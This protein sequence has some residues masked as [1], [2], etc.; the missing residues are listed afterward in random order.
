[1]IREQED[2]GRAG[3][4]RDGLVV[5]TPVQGAWV[6]SLAGDPTCCTASHPKQGGPRGGEPSVPE[7]LPWPSSGIH[8]Q[9][10]HASRLSHRGVQ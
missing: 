5:K 8:P 3:H 4:F 6:Q 2:L 1:M 9:A 7:H 10:H